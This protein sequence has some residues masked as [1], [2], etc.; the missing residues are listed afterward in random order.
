MKHHSHQN[1][2]RQFD[3]KFFFSEQ[4]LGLV[5]TG[6]MEEEDEDE[7][8]ELEE[9]E[10]QETSGEGHSMHLI[11]GT[12]LKDGEDGVRHVLSSQ[13]T[14]THF[15]TTS[16]DIHLISSSVVTANPSNII[17]MAGDG[18]QTQQGQTSQVPQTEVSI[19]DG[20]DEQL[21]SNQLTAGGSRPALKSE[22]LANIEEWSTGTGE[23]SFTNA[24][25][26]RPD[27][28]SAS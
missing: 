26:P 2:V 7:E 24:N 19:P 18:P 5:Q 25:D 15:T 23:S 27:Q 22:I 21:Q 12:I 16:A 8:E 1:T 10:D 9:Q 4:H 28:L 13:E 11:E 3:L 17:T 6:T 14:S 20:V